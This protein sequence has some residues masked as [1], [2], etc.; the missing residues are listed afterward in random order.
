MAAHFTPLKQNPDGPISKSF[1][2]LEASRS[3]FF[4]FLLVWGRPRAHR[5]GTPR[6]SSK[7]M[8]VISGRGWRGFVNVDMH[9]VSPW[10][11]FPRPILKHA[12]AFNL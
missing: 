1:D 8:L 11:S 5:N 10:A 12:I 4:F 3:T 2:Y 6:V 7:N 9:T